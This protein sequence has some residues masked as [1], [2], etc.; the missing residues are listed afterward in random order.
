MLQEPSPPVCLVS[1]AKARSWARELRLSLKGG[2][3]V[4][5]EIGRDK[6]TLANLLATLLKSSRHVDRVAKRAIWRR[7][8]P[9]SLITNW[10]SM[11]SCAEE[12]DRAELLPIPVRLLRDLVSGGKEAIQAA[13]PRHLRIKRPRHDHLVPNIRMNLAAMRDDR[14]VDVEEEAGEKVVHA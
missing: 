7:E 4:A 9:H 13:S 10:A 1:P 11:Q 6:Q 8:F 5:Q 14:F 2:A 3:Y 12:R